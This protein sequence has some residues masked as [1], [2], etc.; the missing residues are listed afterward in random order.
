VGC[1][2]HELVSREY[3]EIMLDTLETDFKME[4]ATAEN[5]VAF[6]WQ[7]KMVNS[8]ARV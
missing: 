5:L 2:I 4:S 8:K 6:N 3:I 1:S 7:P